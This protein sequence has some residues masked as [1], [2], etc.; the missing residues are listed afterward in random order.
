MA[1]VNKVVS[2]NNDYLLAVTFAQAENNKTLSY[3]CFRMLILFHELWKSDYTKKTS[4]LYREVAKDMQKNPKKYPVSIDTFNNALDAIQYESWAGCRDINSDN[5]YSEKHIK[6]GFYVF[7]DQFF[8]EVC[9][10][11]INYVKYVDAI[12]NIA[13]FL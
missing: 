2:K 6:N 10:L 1:I 12:V 3:Q 4:V 9:S 5:T 7:S 8:D 11:S 13:K